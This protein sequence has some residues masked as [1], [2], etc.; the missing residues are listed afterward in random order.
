MKKYSSPAVTATSEP[1]SFAIPAILA[2]ASAATAVVYAAQKVTEAV[3]AF[4]NINA[5]RLEPLLPCLEA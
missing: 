4:G 3:D 2:V 1:A 5:S